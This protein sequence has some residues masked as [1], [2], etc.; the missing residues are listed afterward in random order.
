MT[1]IY[2]ETINYLNSFLNLEKKPFYAYKA[3]LKL[4]RVRKMADNLGIGYRDL[5]T[6]HIAGTKGK[7]S[8]AHFLAYCLAS[9]GHRV[10]VFSSPHFF[11]FRER[12][13]TIEFKENKFQEKLISEKKLAGIVAGFKNKISFL[14]EEKPTYFELATLIGFK[15]F[16]DLNLEY[17]V[18]ETGLG[19][20]LDATNI[21]KPELSI[22]THIGYDHMH[23]LGSSLTQIAFEKAGI[24]KEKIPVISC[25]QR[26]TVNTVLKKAA[27]E[28]NS[29][30]YFL[31]E[32]FKIEDISLEKK[33]TLF[34]FQ[35]NSKKIEKIKISQKGIY[36]TD[37]AALA[38]ASLFLLL[39][40]KKICLLRL[41]R[42]LGRCTFEGRFEVVSRQ[43]LVV[44]DVAHNQS[45]AA[46][47]SDNLKKY[48]PGKKVIL[49]F[50]CANDKK[51]NQM[52]SLIEYNHLILTQ[53]NQPRAYD[54][55]SLRGILRKKKAIVTT[56]LNQALEKTGLIY[57]KD[58]LILICGSFYL[59]AEAKNIFQKKKQFKK[60]KCLSLT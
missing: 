44:V 46:A 45:S 20:R 16:R 54:V 31:G 21:I 48:F 39:P 8:T 57:D 9:L 23:L 42:A 15:Y 7:G 58:S 47:V 55:F 37:N 12:I 50:S 30:F 13:K 27:R 5:K 43:P 53:F 51:P 28:K 2:Q 10:G 22:I 41:R 59:A 4:E 52:L 14:P 1:G 49:I 3:S 25:R 17:V 32:D 36:Q 19:G 56:N 38:L 34:N 11:T 24:I 35:F 6:I 18:V 40:K 26:K 29:P 60:K 33:S